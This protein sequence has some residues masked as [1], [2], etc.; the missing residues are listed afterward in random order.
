MII[1]GEQVR[2]I[3]LKYVPGSRAPIRNGTEIAG[4]YQRAR[5]SWPSA[6]SVGDQQDDSRTVAAARRGSLALP[7]GD[8]ALHTSARFSGQVQ[9]TGNTDCG[10]LHG[11]P[12]DCRVS[13]LEIRSHPATA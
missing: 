7:L 3:A 6:L 10:Q 11:S 2:T 8:V 13:A 12:D 1:Q 5:R 4:E 9:V